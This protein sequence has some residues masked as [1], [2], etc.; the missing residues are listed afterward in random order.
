MRIAIVDDQE[1]W[2]KRILQ[3]VQAYYELRE[4]PVECFSS[5]EELIRSRKSFDL[6]LMDVEMT[7]MDGFETAKVYCSRFPETE[8]VILT[9]HMEKSREGYEIEAFRYLDKANM[10]EDLRNT[11]AAVDSLMNVGNILMLPIVDGGSMEI[12]ERDIFYLEAES[13]GSRIH[14]AEKDLRTSL[15]I[16]EMKKRLNPEN[17]YQSHRAFLVNWD[18]VLDVEKGYILLKDRSRVL[19]SGRKNTEAAGRFWEYKT[20]RSRG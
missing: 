16:A 18:K 17:F 7:G 6:I 2:R 9:V 19:L 4:N 5:G 3:E 12:P 20:F 13:H 14:L 15:G 11:L 8:I 1:F 10:K